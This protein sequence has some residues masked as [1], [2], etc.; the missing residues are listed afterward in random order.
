MNMETYRIEQIVSKYRTEEPFQ[1][2]DE[3]KIVS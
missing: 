1:K 3:F 2:K